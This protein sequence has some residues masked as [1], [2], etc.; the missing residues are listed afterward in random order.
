MYTI[1]NIITICEENNL[2]F[3]KVSFSLEILS[4]SIRFDTI[5]DFLL[6]VRLSNIKCVF[7]MEIYENEEDYLIAEDTIEKII[8]IN[9]KN[10]V[11]SLINSDIKEY[12][13]K[14]SNLRFDLPRAVFIICNFQSQLF[15]VCL[16]N[17]VLLDNNEIK[18]P[19]EV[20]LEILNFKT[21][22]I[23]EVENESKRK[24]EEQ[25]ELLK[26]Y[27]INDKNFYLSSNKDLRNDYSLTLYTGIMEERFKELKS[28]WS[29][30]YSL[31]TKGLYSFI[32]LLWKEYGKRKR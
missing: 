23:V 18:E 25:K 5:D 26:N 3:F 32:E 17:L 16:E 20:L 6:F 15:S 8:N 7:A 24:I 4:K 28:Y 12:N 11:L 9:T 19:E 13:N 21:E 30:P 31:P 27:I 22:M 10:K 14:I 2:T 1:D 29:T